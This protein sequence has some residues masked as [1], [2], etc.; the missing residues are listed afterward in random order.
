MKRFRNQ[1][2]LTITEVMIVVV[3]IGVLLSIAIPRFMAAMHDSDVKKILKRAEI[4]Q[5]ELKK[6]LILDCR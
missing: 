6:W 3:I 2:G 4:A 5:E 1:K